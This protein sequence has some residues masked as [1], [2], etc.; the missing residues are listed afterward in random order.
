MATKDFYKTLGV[1]EKASADEL[2]K[3]YRKLA[4]KYHPD[5]TGGDKAKE[6]KF[7]ELTEA[8]ETL[9][10]EKRRAQY[11]EQRTNPFGAGMPGGGAPA[12]ASP[13]AARKGSTSTTCSRSSAAAAAADASTATRRAAAAAARPR[14]TWAAS[15]TSSRCSAA[16]SRAAAR[17]ARAAGRSRRAR[18]R[19]SS[20]SST[21]TSRR[22][23]RRREERHRRRQ[24]AQDQDPARR[25]RRQ[26][27]PPRRPGR[28]VAGQ[29]VPP[30]DLL[31]ELHEKPHPHFR[32]K[33]REPGRHR[34]RR[35]GPRRR[36]RARRQGAGADARGHDGQPV[37][38]AG[39]L[40]GAT[41]APQGK[42][43]DAG[44]RQAARRPLRRGQRPGPVGDLPATAR[45]HG[46]VREA[47]RRSSAA[48]LRRRAR[49]R[50]L[51]T[52]YERAP[53][54]LPCRRCP[55][56]RCATS[57]CSPAWSCP[58]TSVAQARSSWSTTS[59]AASR[60]AS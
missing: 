20:P 35:A 18:G 3:A 8:Y 39:Q 32:R 33:R 52:I 55:S 4:K 21:S 7:K 6:A 10:D 51:R 2:K 9:G 40:V 60:R 56:C 11:D 13:A 17:R 31:I 49:S 38:P 59:C 27:H 45:A 14:A 15:A 25:H 53:S 44:G 54:S 22:R 36:R 5:V 41:A 48:P 37:D 42:G 58:S 34:G 26:D 46:G 12:R 23:A 1:S 19:T 57:S 24:V 43:R 30:G 50:G 29:G 47:A 16:S 28:A